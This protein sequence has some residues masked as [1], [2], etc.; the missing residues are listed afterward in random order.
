MNRGWGGES[1]LKTGDSSTR[2]P[3]FVERPA[4]W[5]RGVPFAV[6][7]V[8]HIFEQVFHSWVRVSTVVCSDIIWLMRGMQE[9]GPRRWTIYSPRT[10]H[11]PSVQMT[12]LFLHPTPRDYAHDP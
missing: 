10:R 7:I 9:G 12:S 6:Q 8:V 11:R 1:A 2:Y 3:H 4:L 5:R